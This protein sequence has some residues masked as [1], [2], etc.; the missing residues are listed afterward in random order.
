[1]YGIAIT[2]M[3][4]QQNIS[5]VISHLFLYCV[6]YAFELQ[7]GALDT[8]LTLHMTIVSV[9]SRNLFSMSIGV[10]RRLKQIPFI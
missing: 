2:S 9:L 4:Q 6:L 3:T 10:W 1:M 7:H 5:V 8:H